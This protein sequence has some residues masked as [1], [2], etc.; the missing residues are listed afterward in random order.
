MFRKQLET[1]PDLLPKRALQRVCFRGLQKEAKYMKSN[2]KTC[3]FR[4]L[5]A[6][7]GGGFSPSSVG[8]KQTPLFQGVFHV[9]GTN[10][11]RGGNGKRPGGFVRPLIRNEPM[12]GSG[13]SL[14]TDGE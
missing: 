13:Y 3:L 4:N 1:A 9:S 2:N 8:L 6:H 7:Y 11:G 5:P 10:H 14:H 12:G